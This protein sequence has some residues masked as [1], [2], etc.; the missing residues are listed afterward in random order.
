VSGR[1][2]VLTKLDIMDKGTDCRDVLE[3]Q[4]V[5]LKHGWVGVVNR[6]QADI[7]SRMDMEA[8]RSR[9]LDFFKSKSE[10][11]DL[12]NVG[13]KFLSTK[14]STHL[15]G[16][17]RKQ[18]PVIQ[19]AINDGCAPSHAIAHSPTAAYRPAQVLPCAEN[20][21]SRDGRVARWAGR[22]AKRLCWVP[23]SLGA[24]GLAGWCSSRVAAGCGTARYGGDCADA[25]CLCCAASSSWRRS[26]TRWEAPRPRRAAP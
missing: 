4:A 20:P 9:E 14:L 8:A 16:A 13:T 12:K 26:W 3:G 6:G 22:R 2:G 15:I 19:S 5:R 18:L 1:A 17:I 11:R 23:P 24:L 10:Y 21:C 25:A 7:N